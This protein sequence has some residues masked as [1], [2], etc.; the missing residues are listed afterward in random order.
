MKIRSLFTN[1]DKLIKPAT[2]LAN[3]VRT[4]ESDFY[5][6][7]YSLW[8]YS[9][10]EDDTSYSLLLDLSQFY[11]T[12]KDLTEWIHVLIIQDSKIGVFPQLFFAQLY[13]QTI[14]S[15]SCV[16][17]RYIGAIEIDQIGYLMTIIHPTTLKIDGRTQ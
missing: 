15:L 8:T 6:T 13:P 2:W 17:A 1:G 10:L 14:W 11:W 4:I 12:L 16:I 7:S 5:D 9:L 3:P